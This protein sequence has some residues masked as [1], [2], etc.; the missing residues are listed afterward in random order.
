M[1][2]G[3]LQLNQGAKIAGIIAVGLT[4]LLFIWLTRDS[5]EVKSDTMD[6]LNPIFRVS[7]FFENVFTFSK[8]IETLES[9]KKELEVKNSLLE[10]RVSELE[11]LLSFPP[12]NRR[13][14]V[15][16]LVASQFPSSP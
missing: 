10:A 16:A 3:F 12:E 4:T 6:I 15:T 14:G 7:G 9:E 5:S 8:D 11:M 2:K 1:K 13:K